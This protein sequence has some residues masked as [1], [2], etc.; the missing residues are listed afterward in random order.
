MQITVLSTPD[1]SL[2][3]IKNKLCAYLKCQPENILEYITD[4]IK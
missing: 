4:E 3:I 2:F 1:T